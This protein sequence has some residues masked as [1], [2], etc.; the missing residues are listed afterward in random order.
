MAF[1]EWVRLFDG[2]AARG[3]M[4]IGG[5]DFFDMRPVT[6]RGDYVLHLR[7][8]LFE[9]TVREAGFR[10]C[11]LSGGIGRRPPLG[12]VHHQVVEQ[13]GEHRSEL[14]LYGEGIRPLFEAVRLLAVTEGIEN[15]T[16]RRR[17]AEL[18]RSGFEY[19]EEVDQA[20][21]YL[22]T[23]LIHHQLD[24]LEEGGTPDN[25]VDPESLSNLEK[26]TLKEAFQLA[27][28]LYDALDERAR[29]GGS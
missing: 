13:S 22:L 7:H 21:D 14:D 18:A 29:S 6:G 4:P 15:Y 17:A 16:T 25:Y 5:A 2:W 20:L 24:Q 8:Y 10:D 3:D 1:S 11:L 19:A 12:F 26:K 28:K 23:L 27:G 9:L